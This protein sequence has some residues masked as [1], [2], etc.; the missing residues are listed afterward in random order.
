M[1]IIPL[2]RKQST[3][4]SNAGPSMRN[5]VTGRNN[6]I[7]AQALV[8]VVETIERLPDRWQEQSNAA[9]MRALLEVLVSPAMAEILREGVGAH[10][11]GAGLLKSAS[12]ATDN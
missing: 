10:L 2:P 9:D 11:D 8:Y 1:T 7:L 4:K 12:V 3:T 6:F 5:S